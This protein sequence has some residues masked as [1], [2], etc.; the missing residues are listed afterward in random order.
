MPTMQH[1]VVMYY[2]VLHLSLVLYPLILADCPM[3]RLHETS[4][5]IYC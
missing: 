4:P 1:A 3:D 2:W 5:I